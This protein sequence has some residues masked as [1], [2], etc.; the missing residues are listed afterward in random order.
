MYIH[1]LFKH[2]FTPNQNQQMMKYFAYTSF[3]AIASFLLVAFGPAA[4]KLSVD[5]S[6]SSIQ[7]TGKKVTGQHEGSVQ[8][9]S[10]ELMLEGNQL[11]GGTFVADMNT[12]EITDL[13]GKMK[14]KLLGHLQS[15]DFFSI[16][17]FGTATFTLTK[18]TPASKNDQGYTHSL[19]GKMEIKGMTQELTFMAKVEM[20]KDMVTA[21]ADLAVDRT[22]HNIRYGSG[23]FFDNLGDQTIDDDFLLTVSITAKR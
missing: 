9:K 1:I 12:I 3:L 8:L 6:Q 22:Q 19:K 16:S 11:V 13:K 18:V 20:G 4:T 23:S 15:D 7:W 2:N 17:D 14:S 21:T 5:T 10:G